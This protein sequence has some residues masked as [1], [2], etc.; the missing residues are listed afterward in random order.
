MNQEPIIR[1]SKDD[2]VAAIADIYAHHV[3]HGTA[4]FEIEPPD[5]EEIARRRWEVIRKGLPYD[6]AEWD[7]VVVGYAYAAPY[8]PR[9]AYRFTVEDSVYVHPGYARRGIGRA[10]LGSVIA[11]CEQLGYGQMIAVIG[12]SDNLASIS[13]HEAFGFSHAG[14]LRSVGFKF[15]R[16]L[17][18]VLMQ[19]ALSGPGI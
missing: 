19:R 11:Q 15:D 9:L 12:G 5:R 14:T 8:R 18:T 4:S 16:W 6:V 17:D 10:L 3:L 2:D 13:L 1:P 7:G